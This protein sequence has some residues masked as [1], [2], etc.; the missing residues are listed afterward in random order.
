MVNQV[1]QTVVDPK[2]TNFGLGY[3]SPDLLPDDLIAKQMAD[4]AHHPSRNDILQYSYQQGYE[5]F[6]VH[7]SNFIKIMSG[8]DVDP[9]NLFVSN[10]ISGGLHLTCSILTKTNDLIFVEDTS[11][12]IGIKIFQSLGLNVVDIKTQQAGIDFNHLEAKLEAGE[13]PKIFYVIPFNHNPRGYNWSETAKQR[14]VELSQKYGFYIVS[15]EVY[16]YLHFAEE[17]P[18]KSFHN[19]PNDRVVALNT[20][21]KILAPGLRLGWIETSPEIIKRLC[22]NPVIVSGGAVNPIGSIIVESLLEFGL[23]NHLRKLRTTLAKRRTAMIE[24]LLQHFSENVQ[25]TTPNGGYFVWVKFPVDWITRPECLEFMLKEYGVKYQPG[26]NFNLSRTQ[27]RDCIRLSFSYYT[28]DAI[29]KG[30]EQLH[31]G[32]K[33]FAKDYNGPPSLLPNTPNGS[34][35]LSVYGYLGRMG[36]TIMRE[37]KLATQFG[38]QLVGLEKDLSNLPANGVVIDVSSSEGCTTLLSKLSGQPL[39]IGTT[40]ALP[41]AQIK[42]YQQKSHVTLCSNFSLGVN[43]VKEMLEHVDSSWR[44]DIVDL[45]HDQKRDNPSGTALSLAK[46][47]DKANL[48]SVHGIRA[49]SNYGEHIV[50]IQRDGEKIELRHQCLD[51]KIFGQGAIYLAKQILNVIS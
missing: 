21:S 14:L 5:N 1:V 37:E 6:R 17:H 3:P 4:Y 22:E 26:I 29:H 44:V 25:W 33:H 49:G 35:P 46:C 51:R 32:Y 38:F 27:F 28:P 2:V 45:H 43:L 24:G 40:G 7:L 10:G 31:K 11:Y 16:E 20:F 23:I 30:L 48:G 50:F 19:Y 47:V 15:D 34:M 12:F 13:I 36:S 18:Y 41:F 39:I 8:R 9:D 42:E